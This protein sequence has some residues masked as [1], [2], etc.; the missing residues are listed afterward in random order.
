MFLGYIFLALFYA[1]SL[2]SHAAY[3]EAF[4]PLFSG[5][6]HKS[7]RKTTLRY[8]TPRLMLRCERKK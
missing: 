3:A 5:S 4:A 6:C 2:H 8:A 7:W 1:H